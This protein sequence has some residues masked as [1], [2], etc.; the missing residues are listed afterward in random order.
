MALEAGLTRHPPLSLLSSSNCS[1]RRRYNVRTI[2][3][4]HSASSDRGLIIC[5]PPFPTH[6]PP[7]RV[8]HL[9]PGPAG[10][11]ILVG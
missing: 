1:P 8:S 5:G 6:T 9:S 10:N 4:P 3:Q 7:G 2:S 11:P